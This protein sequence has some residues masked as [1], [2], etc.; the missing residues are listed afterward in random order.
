MSNEDR[1]EEL[2]KFRDGRVN[3]LCATDIASR[4]HDI[5][6]V[7]H[8]VNY[9]FPKFMA[10]YVHRC[11]RTGRIGNDLKCEVTSLI[12]SVREVPLLNEIETAARRETQLSG[13]NN[14]IARLIYNKQNAID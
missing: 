4:G 10:D 3:V 9:E 13:V 12:S 5:P 14:N 11:G 7:R 1:V 2:R 8:V 6:R